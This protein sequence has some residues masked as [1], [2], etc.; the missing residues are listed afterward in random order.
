MKLGAGRKRFV[1]ARFFIAIRL[2]FIQKT[3]HNL[4]CVAFFV[5]TLYIGLVS[6][7]L[8][9]ELKFFYFCKKVAIARPCKSDRM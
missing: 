4:H 5:Y 7:Y 1:S 3:Q 6:K 9:H 8:I 2:F